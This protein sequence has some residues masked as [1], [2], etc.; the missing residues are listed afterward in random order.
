MTLGSQ[1]QW[2]AVGGSYLYNAEKGIGG[3]SLRMGLCMQPTP[4]Q[5]VAISYDNNIFRDGHMGLSGSCKVTRDSITARLFGTLDI[6]GGTHHRA[7]LEV[8][9]DVPDKA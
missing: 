5:Q 4:N 2:C 3:S 6:H 1:D 7:G 9:Y 8:I